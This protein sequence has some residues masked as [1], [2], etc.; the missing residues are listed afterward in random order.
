VTQAS[1]GITEINHNVSGSSKMTAMMSEGVGQVKA[2]S[3]EVKENSRQIRASA[4][5]LSELS[6]KLTQLVSKFTI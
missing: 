2:R 6:E 4:D 5:E 1:S 3:I